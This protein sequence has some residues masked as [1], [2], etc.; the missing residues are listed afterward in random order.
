MANVM[1]ID[2]SGEKSRRFAAILPEEFTIMI[3]QSGNS[4]SSSRAVR[5]LFRKTIATNAT[6]TKFEGRAKSW[7]RD[8]NA[9]WI[10][11]QMVF[12]E[13][14]YIHFLYKFNEAIRQKKQ[15]NNI[16]H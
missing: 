4:M 16:H 14:F 2:C 3:V 8:N 7:R 13:T 5:K 15:G 6:M 10:A 9:S 11:S 12:S 1:F